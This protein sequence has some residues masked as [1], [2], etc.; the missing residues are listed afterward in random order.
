MNHDSNLKCLSIAPMIQ[1]T[2]R[3]WRVF[4]REFSKKTLLYTEMTM[5]GALTYNPTKLNNFIGHNSIEHPLAIQLG[6][7]DPNRLSEAAYLC[8]SYANFNEININCGC[9]SNKA[10]RTG[11]GGELMLEPNLVRE[12]VSQMKRKV[13]HTD[14]TVKCRIGVYKN[15]FIHRD[16]WENL[17]EFIDSIK[18][19]GVNHVYVHARTCILSGLTP[20]QNRNVPPLHY[21]VVHKLVETFP[22]MKFTLNGGVKSF[23]EG[24]IYIY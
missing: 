14:I 21:E 9:P 1:Y 2:D 19:G 16:T 11:F 23:E 10:I 4:F 15:D 13:T 6:G 8:E 17:V 22:D 3:H 5:D 12:I 24:T 7:N 20:A 18:A